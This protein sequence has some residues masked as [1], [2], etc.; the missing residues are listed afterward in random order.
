MVH[1]HDKG[2]SLVNRSAQQLCSISVR[3]EEFLLIT[4]MY[5]LWVQ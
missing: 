2:T 5:A 4:L 3:V 1:C